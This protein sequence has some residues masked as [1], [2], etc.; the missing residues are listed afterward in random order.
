MDRKVRLI[1]FDLDNTLFPFDDLWLKAN[2]NTFKEY[3]LFKV[4]NYS[5]FM[6]LY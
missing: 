4:I 5:D 1:I 6:K 2:R 3:S